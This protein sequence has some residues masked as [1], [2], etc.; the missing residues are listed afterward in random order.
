MTEATACVVDPGA[1]GHLMQCMEIWGGNQ[2]TERAVTMSGLEAWVYSRPYADATGGGDVHYVSSCATGRITRVQDMAIGLRTLMRKYVNFIDQ[3]KFVQAMNAQFAS[4]SKNGTFATAVVTTF[5]APTNRLSLCNAGHP[6]PLIYRAAE[7]AWSYL[8]LVES[9]DPDAACNLPLGVLDI[10][11]YEQ[12]DVDLQLGDFVLCYTDS[13]CESHA[14]DGSM[15]CQGG[16]LEAANAVPLDDPATYVPR[17]L[18]HIGG[19]REG[20]L[21]NDDVTTLLFRPTGSAAR[22][23]LKNK[24]LAPFRVARGILGSIGRRGEPAPWPELSVANLGGAMLDPLGKV[25]QKPAK[26]TGAVI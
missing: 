15:L 6:P 19:L 7:R 14:A 2:I 11:D 10:G 5:F 23:P 8:E 1:A 13:L 22:T 17:L 12:F 26:D 9:D 21:Q 16:L 3:T 25:G 20:N 4:Q 18:A 24:L